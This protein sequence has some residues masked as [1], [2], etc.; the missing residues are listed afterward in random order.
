MSTTVTVTVEQDGIELQ[1]KLTPESYDGP[2]PT[3]TELIEH[4]AKSCLAAIAD[5]DLFD[6]SELA[7]LDSLDGG[8]R[9]IKNPEPNRDDTAPPPE[10]IEDPEQDWADLAAQESDEQGMLDDYL[11]IEQDAQNIH[12][13]DLDP[14]A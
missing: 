13:R 9:W 12:I 6:G 11:A 2:P 7:D 1:I 5:F 10:A 8:T 4:A 3:L 14:R